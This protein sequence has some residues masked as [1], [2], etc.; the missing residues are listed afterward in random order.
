MAAED[1]ELD[2]EERHGRAAKE[3]GAGRRRSTCAEA[4][5]VLP[6]C[7][8][9]VGQRHASSSPNPG[10][11]GAASLEA[12]LELPGLG[13]SLF[14]CRTGPRDSEL[15]QQVALLR[16]SNLGRIR[17]RP[18]LLAATAVSAKEEQGEVAAGGRGTPRS[19]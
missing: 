1:G 15:R 4:D 7:R 9:G 19:E 18:L 8:A 11:G 3:K 10:E 5:A 13:P 12:A 17:H 2:K 14:D 6:P 16:A